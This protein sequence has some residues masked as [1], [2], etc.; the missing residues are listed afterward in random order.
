MSIAVGGGEGEGVEGMLESCGAAHLAHRF[1]TVE[2]V[3]AAAIITLDY[4]GVH[5]AMQHSKA[6]GSVWLAAV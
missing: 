1:E 3:H 5:K 4:I 2:K 6:V